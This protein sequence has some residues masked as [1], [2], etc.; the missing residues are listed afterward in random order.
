VEL[1]A[2]WDRLLRLVDDAY[3]WR[4]PETVAAAAAA[5]A[6]LRLLVLRDWRGDPEG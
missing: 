4:D 1:N 3:T 6:R 2:E 5:L